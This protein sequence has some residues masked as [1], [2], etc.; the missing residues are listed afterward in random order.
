MERV[1]LNFE[2][3]ALTKIDALHDEPC[4][5]AQHGDTHAQARHN[6][7]GQSRD[8]TCRKV[9]PQNR[10]EE[11]KGKQGQKTSSKAEYPEGAV[12]PVHPEDGLENLEAIA[13]GAELGSTA[14]GTVAVLN[15]NGL[16]PEAVF[17][18]E[19]GQLGLKLET[20]A[21]DW[22]GLCKKR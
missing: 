16:Y 8:K 12:I 9:L 5:K 18:G 7:G 1:Q 19:D 15:G 10:N 13:I 17:E 2:I 3:L 20:G 11:H 21:H 14:F 6:Q 22:K 4:A